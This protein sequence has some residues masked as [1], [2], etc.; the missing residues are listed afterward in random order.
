MQPIK[1]KIKTLKQM[2]DEYGSDY[3]G[4]KTTPSFN[5]FMESWIPENRIMNIVPVE[6]HIDLYCIGTC[7]G[8]AYFISSEHIEYFIN[9]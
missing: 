7:N 2:I 8:R 3:L 6:G 5:V 9:N 4:V 1:G